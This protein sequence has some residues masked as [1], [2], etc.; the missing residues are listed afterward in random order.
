MK[1][2]AKEGPTG[3]TKPKKELRNEVIVLLP[4]GDAVYRKCEQIID[5]NPNEAHPKGIVRKTLLEIAK[6]L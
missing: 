5:Q 6:H 4:F 1:K 2:N 3:S